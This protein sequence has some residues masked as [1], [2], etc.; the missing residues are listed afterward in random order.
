[1]FGSEYLIIF[2]DLLIYEPSKVKKKVHME[3]GSNQD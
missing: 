1:M 3:R 2:Y